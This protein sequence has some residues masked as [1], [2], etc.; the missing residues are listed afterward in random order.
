MWACMFVCACVNACVYVCMC[1]YTCA[2]VSVWACIRTAFC[3]ALSGCG[4]LCWAGHR[5][6]CDT[7]RTHI[8]VAAPCSG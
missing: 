4:G 2:G 5:G 8:D 6:V 7:V 1:E 3:S